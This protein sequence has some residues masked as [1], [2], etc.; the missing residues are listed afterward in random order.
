MK[1]EEQKRKG[2]S[3]GGL[4]PYLVQGASVCEVPDPGFLDFLARFQLC[5]ACVALFMSCCDTE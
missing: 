5:L 1:M 3:K 4:A 2:S